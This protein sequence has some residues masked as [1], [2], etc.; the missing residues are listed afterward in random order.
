MA[1]YF[2]DEPARIFAFCLRYQQGDLRLQFCLPE[3]F[4]V[5]PDAVHWIKN[6]GL[7]NHGGVHS[8]GNTLRWIRRPEGWECVLTI[9]TRLLLRPFFDLIRS[10]H[11]GRCFPIILRAVRI[12]RYGNPTKRA[13][14]APP[15]HFVAKQV[16]LFHG[17]S[18]SKNTDPAI[19][20]GVARSDVHV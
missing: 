13:H 7:S 1:T 9:P 19:L 15:A 17:H 10:S 20:L 16:I 2:D 11:P 18:T 5:N 14:T 8:W 3:Q 12:E 6:C 4:V